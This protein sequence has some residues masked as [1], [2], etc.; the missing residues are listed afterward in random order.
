MDNGDYR[1]HRRRPRVDVRS[2]RPR[3]G[4]TERVRLVEL[5][6]ALPAPGSLL[7][8]GRTVIRSTGSKTVRT[9]K[10]ALSIVFLCSVVGAFAGRSL[11]YPPFLAKAKKFGAKDCTFCHVDPEGGPPWNARGQWLIKEKER[12]GADSVDVE[13]LADYKPEK[14][15]DKADKKEDKKTDKTDEKKDEKKPDPTKPPGEISAVERELLR[16]ERDWL[17]SYVKHE[18]AA[19]ERLEADDFMIVYSDGSVLNK[20]KEIENLKAPVREGPQPVVSTE[21]TKVRI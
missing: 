16:T 4:W 7:H 1:E 6:S 13:W 12:R 10:V 11:A 3:R 18:V 19:M 9:A 20:A 21:G 2:L 8:T 14:K 17:D 5:S 15:D